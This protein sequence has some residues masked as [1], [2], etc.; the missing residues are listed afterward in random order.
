M[1]AEFLNPFYFF[2]LLAKDKPNEHNIIS[3]EFI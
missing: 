3:S 2:N 1:S